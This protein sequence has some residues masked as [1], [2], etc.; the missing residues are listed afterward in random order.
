MTH[1]AAKGGGHF[2]PSGQGVLGKGEQPSLIL[3]SNNC[4]PNQ[5]KE[6]Q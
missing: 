2:K 6:V 1:K 5:G 4:A 3:K